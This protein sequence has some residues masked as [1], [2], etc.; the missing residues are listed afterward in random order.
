MTTNTHG[1]TSRGL[2]SAIEATLQARNRPSTCPVTSFAPAL[3]TATEWIGDGVA[4]FQIRT[5]VSVEPA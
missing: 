3:T 4:T 5:I 2:A 1:E